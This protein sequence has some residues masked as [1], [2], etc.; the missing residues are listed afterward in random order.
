LKTPLTLS[1]DKDI[2]DLAETFLH[3]R[4]SQKQ[5]W[6]QAVDA[7]DRDALRRIGHEIKGTAGAFGFGDLSATGAALEQ[8]AMDGDLERA[9]EMTEKMIDFLDRATVVPD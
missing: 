7:A 3:N 6:R 4:R 8:S 5:D 9:R 1:V 2:L